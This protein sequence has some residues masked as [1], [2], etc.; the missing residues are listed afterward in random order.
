MA[1]RR[2]QLIQQE[3]LGK[4]TPSPF[5]YSSSYYALKGCT[6][7]LKK[8]VRAK[9]I[10]S[11]SL[12]KRGPKLTHLFFVDDS[13]LFCKAN[14]QECGNVL[15][16][17]SKYEVVF[18]EKINRE[19][20]AL[21]FSK[22]TD[23]DT[24]QE[25]KRLLGVQEIKFYEKYLGLLALVGRGKKASFNYIK[26]KVWR[27]LQGWEGKL[28]SQVG[29]EILIK[30]VVKAISTYAMGCFKLPLGLCHDMEAMIKKFFWGQRVDKRRIHWNKWLELTKSKLAGG[31]GF[32]DL[33]LFNDSLI[34]KQ[35]W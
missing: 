18:G 10:N 35:A 26:E 3:E 33:A 5:S 8:A 31:M 7:Y 11:F 24:R 21:F 2:G 25:I 28:L 23:D 4:G 16:T 19:K 32:R 30:A 27:K 20:T 1:S 13:L 22:F 9:E 29:R 14:P 34:A 15:N 17:L 12:C 6:A